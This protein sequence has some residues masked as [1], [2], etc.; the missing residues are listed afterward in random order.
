VIR[1]QNSHRSV[2]HQSLQRNRRP[3]WQR[4]H[5]QHCGRLPPER[6]V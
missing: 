6:A 3:T 4:L 2:A 1:V 5:E